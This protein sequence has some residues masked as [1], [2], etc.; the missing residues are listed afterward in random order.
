MTAADALLDPPAAKAAIRPTVASAHVRAQ[1]IDQ[2]VSTPPGGLS[3]ARALYAPDPGQAARPTSICSALSGRN[4][5]CCNVFDG[6][7]LSTVGPRGC[8]S[9][10]GSHDPAGQ[11]RGHGIFGP[12]VILLR[13]ESR[14]P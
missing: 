7:S 12:F 3:S 5:V 14:S 8:R 1:L 10:P 4:P 6:Q 11:A 9:H 13:H 2:D